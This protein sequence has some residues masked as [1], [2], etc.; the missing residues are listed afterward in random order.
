MFS[1]TNTCT[2]GV[3]GH[4]PSWF[5]SDGACRRGPTRAM[6]A[7]AAE[8]DRQAAQN[9]AGELRAP[10]PEN[11]AASLSP[12]VEPDRLPGE[13]NAAWTISRIAVDRDTREP[14]RAPSLAQYVSRLFTTSTG[15]TTDSGQQGDFFCDIR[16][17]PCERLNAKSPQVS[18]HGGRRQGGSFGQWPG[19]RL[20]SFLGRAR[21]GGYRLR[22]HLRRRQ[23]P[24]DAAA[25]ISNRWRTSGLWCL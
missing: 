7:A 5:A 15:K 1:T 9:H 17:L 16:T 23:G 12:T 11:Q 10:R 24:K 3:T 2:T 8:R 14:R 21:S 25:V 6:G 4:D 19:V 20:A 18:A 13:F 22:R